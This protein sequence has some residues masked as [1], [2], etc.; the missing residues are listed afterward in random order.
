MGDS[1]TEGVG[2]SRVSYVTELTSL[3]RHQ[4]KE[5]RLP[6]ELRANL[7]RLRPVD[8]PSHSRFVVFNL[9][10]FVD[11]DESDSDSNIWLWNLACEG[12]MI[13]SDKQLINFLETISPSVIVIFRGGLESIVRPAT[14]FNNNWPWW[15][16][17]AW[18]G[19]AAMDPRCYFS[20]TWWRKPKQRAV[21]AAKQKARIRLLN[22]SGGRPMLELDKFI[23]TYQIL[24]A[25]IKRFKSRIIIAGM[26]PVDDASFPGSA[27][28]FHLLNGELCAMAEREEVEFLDWGSVVESQVNKSDLYYRDG[29]HFNA[30]G[31]RLLARLLF[32]HIFEEAERA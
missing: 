32:Q 13:D 2:A 8:A 29:F 10:G 27:K 21:D 12:K 17:N 18:R 7:I 1:L 16:P 5:G 3:I 9:A 6:A 4:V 14:F 23:E 15:V 20:T 26:L 19:Y 31:A 24:L 25:N 30:N 11:R 22:T 28:Q